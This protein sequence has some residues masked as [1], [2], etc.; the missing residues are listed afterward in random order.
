MTSPIYELAGQQQ[1]PLSEEVL[2]SLFADQPVRPS[3][4]PNDNRRHWQWAAR[5]TATTTSRV[6]LSFDRPITD[7]TVTELKARAESAL[8]WLIPRYA[9]AVTVTVQQI[10]FD[11]V[12]LGVLVQREREEDLEVGLILTQG[13]S[14]A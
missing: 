8:A 6:W 10:A 1:D 7:D 11:S 3:I 2:A 5:P 4:R 9:R 14:S 12:S 13:A